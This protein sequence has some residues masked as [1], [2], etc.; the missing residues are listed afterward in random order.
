MPITYYCKVTNYTRG[1]VLMMSDG[2]DIVMPGNYLWLAVLI[3]IWEIVWTIVYCNIGYHRQKILSY[4]RF[5]GLDIH[6]RI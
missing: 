5:D 3:V 1:F 6:V 2:L 4:E